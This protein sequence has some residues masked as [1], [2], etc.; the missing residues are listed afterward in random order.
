M[1]S[2]RHDSLVYIY[3]LFQQ[4][5]VMNGDG[6]SIVEVVKWTGRPILVLCTFIFFSEGF[7]STNPILVFPFMHIFF[8]WI[9]NKK[10]CYITRM[11]MSFNQIPLLMLHILSFWLEEWRLDDYSS[12]IL[13]IWMS[14][15]RPISR[16]AHYSHMTIVLLLF[17][18][19]VSKKKK[20]FHLTFFSPFLFRPI[21]L[22]GLRDIQ[23]S[24]RLLD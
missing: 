14:V 12:V 13:I 1:P 8:Y 11:R 20:I 15:C 18:E 16:S 9:W 4:A 6:C 17:V 2:V 10:I 23:L 5:S 7:I 24:L 19:P 3:I 22:Q 21:I